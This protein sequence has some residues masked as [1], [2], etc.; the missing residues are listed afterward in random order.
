MNE[1]PSDQCALR[2]DGSLKDA[3]AIEW[4]YDV[5]DK[6]VP[7]EPAQEGRSRRARPSDKYREAIL[8]EQAD[9]DGVF[10]PQKASKPRRSH[11]RKARRQHPLLDPA[12]SGEESV[13]SD[14]SSNDDSFDSDSEP[15]AEVSNS[16]ILFRRRHALPRKPQKQHRMLVK[17]HRNVLRHRG[18]YLHNDCAGPNANGTPL[19]ISPT[20]PIIFKLSI[21]ELES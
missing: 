10:R 18:R 11:H 4:S 14:F 3:S 13:S 7:M 1:P 16:E 21:F 12:V 19:M 9:D 8:A 5:D 20:P 2:P 17:R 15:D 6:V